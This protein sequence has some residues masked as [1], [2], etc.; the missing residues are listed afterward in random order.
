M[1]ALTIQPPRP[2]LVSDDVGRFDSGRAVLD[3]WLRE[4]AA[5]SDN[6]GASRTYVVCQEDRVIGYYC[7]ANGSVERRQTPGNVR[8][9]MPDPIPVMILGRLAVDLEYQGKSIGRGLLRDAILRTLKAAGIAGIRALLVHALDDAAAEFYRR[10]GFVDS[11][12]DPLILML[13]LAR[14]RDALE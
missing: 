10:N 14:A 13:P 11:P 3:D 5:K 8:R 2:L 9:N 12:I 4:R 1:G 7:L 6:S